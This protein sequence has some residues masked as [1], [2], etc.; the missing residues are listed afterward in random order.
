[1]IRYPLITL[2]RLFNHVFAEKFQ[3]LHHVLL[4]G[5][6]RD[7]VFLRHLV[8]AVVVEIAF[9]EDL[10]CLGRQ[11]IHERHHLIDAFLPWV[12]SVWVC[13][14]RL[15][16]QIAL[17]VEC[18]R[19]TVSYMISAPEAYEAEDETYPFVRLYLVEPFPKNL[20][21][22]LHNV[23]TRLLIAYHLTGEVAGVLVMRLEKLLKFF[24]FLQDVFLLSQF[25]KLRKKTRN[26]AKGVFL[27]S[28]NVEL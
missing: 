27:L 20:K 7:A 19:L 28:I 15:F 6:R 12:C 18:G 1:M 8:V 2:F 22:I 4:Y 14:F 24:L 10:P 23:A 26:E 25:T 11:L 21:G 16:L 3:R 17:G 13:G 5:T 9:G